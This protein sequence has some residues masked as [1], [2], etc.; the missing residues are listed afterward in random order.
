VNIVARFIRS[1]R[2]EGFPRALAFLLEQMALQEHALA[3]VWAL[4]H[5]LGSAE[6]RSA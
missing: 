5:R 6:Q 2:L 1:M 4:E 3:L